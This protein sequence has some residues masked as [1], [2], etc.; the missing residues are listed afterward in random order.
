MRFPSVIVYRGQR[1]VRAEMPSHATPHM[2]CV[3]KPG[4]HVHW[5]EK[6][7]KCLPLPAK[8]Q[9]AVR[10]AHNAGQDARQATSTVSMGYQKGS[11]PATMAQ[12]HTTAAQK[13]AKASGMHRQ[14]AQQLTD[15]GFDEK[16]LDH[17]RHSTEFGNYAAAHK[18]GKMPGGSYFQ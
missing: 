12:H 9:D 3:G 14:V 18:A 4:E 2:R 16:A 1:Y 11:L 7:K 8:L 15:D 6:Q 13:H 17:R 10:A 5:N